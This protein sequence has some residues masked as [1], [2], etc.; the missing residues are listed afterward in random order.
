MSEP[1]VNELLAVALAVLEE[2][3]LENLGVGTISRR[4][5][6]KPPS[7]YKQ[8]TSK[9]DIE[10][11]LADLGFRLWAK[12]L[13]A[14]SG[15]LPASASRRDHIAALAFSY[16]SLGKENPQLFRLMNERPFLGAQLIRAVGEVTTID[17]G[18]LFPTLTAGMSFW[19]W[20]H[21]ILVLEIVGR[22]PPEIDLDV[23]WN[24]M[25][26]SASAIER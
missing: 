9:A 24:T 22:F 21:G 5:G 6:I 10:Q 8:F 14:A 7:L 13:A 17:Y 25:I 23:M 16:R 1:R 18:A 20:G 2:E 3:G 15:A 4:A 19:A 12:E 11:Q 26:D